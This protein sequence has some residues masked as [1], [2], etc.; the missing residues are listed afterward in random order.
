MALAAAVRSRRL[1]A[2]LARRLRPALPHL[3]TSH[4]PDDPPAPSSPLRQAPPRFQPPH[5]ALPQPSGTDQTLALFP[6]GAALAC[7]GSSR[8]SFSSWPSCRTGDA[9]AGAILIDAADAAAAAAPASFPSEIAWVAE[10]SSLSVAAVQHLIDAVHS[11]TGLN[12]WL[13]IALSTLL[14]RCVLFTLSFNARKQVLGMQQELSEVKKMINSDNDEKSRGEVLRRELSV[15]KRLGLPAITLI[16]T[17]YTFGALYFALSNMVEK[18]PSLKEGGT[19]WFTDLTTP[20]ALYIFP[21]MTSLFLIL[22]FEAAIHYSRTPECLEATIAK[23]IGRML[24]LVP[25][26]LTAGLPQAMVIHQP[27]VKKFLYGKQTCPS[28]DEPKGPT[29]EDS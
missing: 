9:G 29:A 28:S 20:D 6:F 15:F 23:N 10:E 2:H 13:S 3:L 5:F 21:V 22:K 26:P 14:L 1:P 24:L 18:L 17:P 19:F 8:R 7:G 4:C 11:F 25:V 16:L 27:V 12:W